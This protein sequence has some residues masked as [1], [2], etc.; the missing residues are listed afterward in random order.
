MKL[1]NAGGNHSPM[2]MAL[3]QILF[4][5][6]LI[7]SYLFPILMANEYNRKIIGQRTQLGFFLF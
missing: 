5:F 6:Y 7:R 3:F 1:V 2:F 4:E